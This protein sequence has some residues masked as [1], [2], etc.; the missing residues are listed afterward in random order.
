MHKEKLKIS[1]C[2]NSSKIL[3]EKSWNHLHNRYQ[4]Y[5]CT[6]TLPLTFHA[7]YNYLRMG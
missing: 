2:R 4:L 6:C 7:W 5:T 1:H 3:L